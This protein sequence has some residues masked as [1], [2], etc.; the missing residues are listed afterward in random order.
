[1]IKSLIK[2]KNILTPIP[3]ASKHDEKVQKTS[4]DLEKNTL[5]VASKRGNLKMIDSLIKA[6][7]A[8]TTSFLH[9]R[10]NMTGKTTRS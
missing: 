4:G 5:L 3:I 10:S 1:M 2:K 8:A 6:G 9:Q 7:A